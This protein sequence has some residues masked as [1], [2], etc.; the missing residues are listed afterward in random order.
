[1]V[2]SID[3]AMTII[4][5]VS[6][7]TDGLGVTELAEKMDLNKSSI[8]RILS[9]LSSHGFI[10]QDVE[11]KKYKLGYKYLE[12]AAKLLDSIDIRKEAMPYLKQLVELSNEVVHLVI[13]S[14]KEAVY[15]EK[16]E[17]SE[18]L[19][20][21][22]QV[23]K[24]VPMHCTSAGKVLL[25]NLPEREVLEI[26]AQ[27]GLSK[28]TEYT[29]TNEKDLFKNLDMIKQ[30]G[31]GIEKEENEPGITCIAAPVFNHLGEERINGLKNTLM[32]VGINISRRLGFKG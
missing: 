24:R 28:H 5:L 21:H 16:L 20:M 1:M 26:I 4:N 23:G 14:Q 8:F 32:E 10:E 18:T 22:S 11:T 3:R 2:Q 6:L 25:A 29:L 9:T 15:I 19:R 7:Q 31:I 13:Y 12:L 17:G 27:K 30:Q